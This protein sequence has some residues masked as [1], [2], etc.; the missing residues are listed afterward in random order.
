MGNLGN[1]RYITSC[2]FTKYGP[3]CKSCRYNFKVFSEKIGLPEPIE[4]IIID[5]YPNLLRIYSIRK[6][7][8]PYL[9]WLMVLFAFCNNL[10][11]G[12]PA[13]HARSITRR[14]HQPCL[15][16]DIVCF[17]QQLRMLR[18][19]VRNTTGKLAYNGP[20]YARLLA[21]TDDMLGP[22][23]MHIKYVSYVY[24]RLCI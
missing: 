6:C 19:P 5:Q 1:P 8:Q 14:C 4:I 10:E 22:S 3:S 18:V 24:D 11:L 20:L 17:L 23:P 13:W 12:V 2:H 9:T 16:D 7:H 15:A 21:M